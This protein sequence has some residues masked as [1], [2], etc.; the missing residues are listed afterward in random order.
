M[1]L[2]VVQPSEAKSWLQLGCLPLSW[3]QETC[4]YVWKYLE[5]MRD[6]RRKLEDV[7]GLM[8]KG[9]NQ[10]LE[11]AMAYFLQQCQTAEPRRFCG[12]LPAGEIWQV[13]KL[14][15]DRFAYAGHFQ[16]IDHGP[17]L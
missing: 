2:Q 15:N 16:V 17:C 8:P 10:V 14:W 7:E 5:T 11:L 12:C 3:N 13:P 4:F 9:Q 6:V 1:S